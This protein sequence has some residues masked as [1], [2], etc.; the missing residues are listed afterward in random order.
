[1]EIITIVNHLGVNLFCRYKIDLHFLSFLNIGMD[2]E[3]EVLTLGKRVNLDNISALTSLA[4]NKLSSVKNAIQNDLVAKTAMTP[5]TTKNTN[6]R[7]NNLISE[8]ILAPAAL[9]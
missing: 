2:W 4:M 3:N 1:M 5:P 8:C 6:A 7:C 9:N